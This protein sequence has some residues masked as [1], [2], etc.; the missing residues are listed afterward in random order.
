MKLRR[1]RIDVQGAVQGVGFR[2]FVYR[3]AN[4][5]ALGGWV[6]NSPH[7]VSIEV[8]GDEKNLHR[9]KVRLENEKPRVA[10]ITALKV[11]PLKPAYYGSFEIRGSVTD[12]EKRAFILPDMATCADCSRELFDPSNPRFRYPFINCTNCGPRFSIIEA[13]PYDRPNTSMKK[14]AMCPE[15]EQEYHDP[16]DRRFHAQPNA[17]PKCGPRI[18][19]WNAK[20]EVLCCKE[21]ALA[22]CIDAIRSGKI[23]ALKGIGGFQLIAD[24]RNE[25]AVRRLRERKHRREKPF[26]LMLPSL[27]SVEGY[28]R[29]TELEKQLL[30]SFQ[31]P[32]V[33]LK[34]MPG[35]S[36]LA[37]SVAPGNP[38]LGIMLPYSPLHHL[39]LRGLAFP[40][41]ATSGNLSDEPICI[42]GDEAVERLGGIAD[43]FLT[44]NRPI[45]RH[46][47]DSI[48]RV[49]MGREIVLR[50]ARGYAPAAIAVECASDSE[51]V[52]AVG[53]QLKNTVALK[54][55]G[56]VFLSQHIGDLETEP[57]L[58]AFQSSS[59]DLPRL[60][61][62][63]PEIIASDLHP[64]Y[65]STKFAQKECE[66]HREIQCVGVQHHYAHILS[67]MAE[68]KLKAPVLGICWDGT[69]LGLDGT[70]WGGEF[71][72]IGE[73][74][75]DRVATLRRFRLPG[76]D[77]AVK[78]PRRAAL[79]L[80]YEIFRDALFEREDLTSFAD[81]STG[82]LKMLQK[83][84]V[85]GANSP[86][87]SSGGRLFDSVASLLGLRHAVDF[88]GQA[89]M[90]LEFAIRRS[91]TGIYE[92]KLR[93]QRPTIVDWQPM[94]LEILEEKRQKKSVG[95]IALKFH[96]TLAEMMVSIARAAGEEKIVLSGGCFQNKY[97]LERTVRR[98]R[99]EGFIPYW[100]RRVPPNDGGIALG[101]V[102][103]ALRARK[104]HSV[105][106]KELCSA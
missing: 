96:H 56:H 60:Y 19:L 1:S 48:T 31:S 103:A 38:Y 35:C 82:E 13:L 12:G 43:L 100:H 4:E 44:H 7:G 91:K 11:S 42:D 10:T 92:F 79:G 46:V 67:C 80:L 32:I 86:F 28:C 68:N 93:G 29:V 17:C 6:L 62:A 55:G 5:L 34:K 22:E 106:T 50:A 63:K 18:E 23:I 98:L 69:G 2:P 104:L 101:Q 59:A 70:I 84:L 8:E 94:I 51:T 74:D 99:E 27:E 26:A 16:N 57:A 88:E 53:G 72:V 25:D 14:F 85:S 61:D 97:L 64:E 87:T 3:L 9:F 20:G 75:F 39:L 45:V 83:M 24:A 49:V 73:D 95:Q 21:R 66:S 37:P 76:G 65:L 71:L 40:V 58:T 33:L 36:A 81:F 105:P 41:V 52:L 102:M 15:C 30:L 47:D 89:A 78:E 90:D 77:A 54:T